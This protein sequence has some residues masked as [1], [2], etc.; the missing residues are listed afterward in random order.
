MTDLTLTDTV[1]LVADEHG[2]MLLNT[3]DGQMYGLNPAAAVF[4]AAL[5][6]GADRETATRSVL[7]TFDA[8]ETVIRADLQ[9][10]IT[11]LHAHRLLEGER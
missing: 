7:E 8:E 6:E 10:L 11:E 9:A 5:R 3:R 2:A 4:C 1:Q